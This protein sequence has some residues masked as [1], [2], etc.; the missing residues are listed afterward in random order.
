MKN[1]EFSFKVQNVSFFGEYFKPDT[2]RA[3]VIL[4]HGM[5]EHSGR[6]KKY[7]I[8]KLNESNI[9]VITFDHFGHGKTEGKRGHNPGFDAVLDSV[10]TVIE[11]SKEVFGDKPL[12]LYGHSMGGNVVINYVLRRKN[13]LTGVI[14]T[15]PFLRLAFEPPKWKMM[16]ANLILKIFP[17]M[18]MDTGLE[19]EAVSR[20]KKVVE[21][22][23]NDPLIHS[24][25][26]P[27]F[28]VVFMETGEWAIQNASKLN[29]PVLLL[30][31]TADRLTSYKASEEL[32]KNSENVTLKLYEGGYHELH[33][34]LVKEEE[35]TDIINWINNKIS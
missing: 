21:D 6:Y 32:A 27:N 31:G 12:F 16:M 20:D 13:D 35:I 5:G 9:G 10:K 11:K 23:I 2:V 1:K 15:S 30:H 33:N 4:V 14:A 8:P 25:V 3:V 24:K 7:V 34:D 22:Y 18:I 29:I 19:A 28:S 17:G 26:S